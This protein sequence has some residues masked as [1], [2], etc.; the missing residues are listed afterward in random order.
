MP[1][2]VEVNDTG[3]SV[4]GSGYGL[5]KNLLSG[6]G[7]ELSINGFKPTSLLVGFAGDSSTAICW[8]FRSIAMARNAQFFVGYR[9]EVI[10]SRFLQLVSAVLPLDQ[11]SVFILASQR[12]AIRL[13]HST[14]IPH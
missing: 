6:G 4:R 7:G 11:N 13:L 12:L 5:F 2:L 8:L 3:Q 9:S 1:T 14:L 10:A